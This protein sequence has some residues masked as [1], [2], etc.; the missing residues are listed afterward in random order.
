LIVLPSP[1]LS[2]TEFWQTT[3]EVRFLH[4]LWLAYISEGVVQST[5]IK[6]KKYLIKDENDP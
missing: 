1:D 2:E 6:C 3:D 4:A 5:G